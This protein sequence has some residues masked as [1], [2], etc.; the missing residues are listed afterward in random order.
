MTSRGTYADPSLASRYLAALY[1]AVITVSTT[2]FGDIT[3]QTDGERAYMIVA[4]FVG[5]VGFG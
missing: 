2:G 1:Y 4:M 5:V 3:A